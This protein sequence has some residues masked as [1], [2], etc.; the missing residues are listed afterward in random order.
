MSWTC[1]TF[2]GLAAIDPI[3]IGGVGA[4][5]VAAIVAIIAFGASRRASARAAATETAAASLTAERDRLREMLRSAAG[6]ASEHEKLAQELD[7]AR[8]EIDSLRTRRFEAHWLSLLGQQVGAAT[9]EVNNRLGAAILGSS[10]LREKIAVL[11]GRLQSDELRRSD[12]E[13][14]ISTALET[15]DLVQPNLRR[16]ADLLVA[17]K[18]VATDQLPGSRRRVELKGSLQ[19]IATTLQLVHKTTGLQ[20]AVE[21]IEISVDRAGA[22]FPRIL[23][24]LVSLSMLGPLAG[25]R[26]GRIRVS[27]LRRG[28]FLALHYS[29]DGSRF[30]ISVAE[31]INRGSE[32][33][34]SAPEPLQPLLELVVRELRGSI[35]VG[36]DPAAGTNLIRI[37]SPLE[38]AV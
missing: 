9:H 19:A 10:S 4:A 6:S 38:A 8:A 33:P 22:A 32:Q 27:L 36:V 23:A 14:F 20:I 7:Q 25:R 21:G 2:I 37:E 3:A 1:A 24:E 35:Q 28:A 16:A 30:P 12:L 29:D 31:A 17:L 34:D 26:D 11:T 13:G 18:Q 15:G 5:I